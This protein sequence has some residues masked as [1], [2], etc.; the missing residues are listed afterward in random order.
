M[1]AKLKVSELKKTILSLNQ[2]YNGL[3]SEREKELDNNYNQLTILN[4][5]IAEKNNYINNFSDFC[6]EK[7]AQ[8]KILLKLSKKSKINLKS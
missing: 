6:Q 1:N 2:R 8:I 4:K 3:Y 7:D 5:E